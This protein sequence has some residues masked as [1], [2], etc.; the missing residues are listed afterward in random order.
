MSELENIRSLEKYDAWKKA[1]QSRE[2]WI[3]FI[4]GIIGGVIALLLTWAIL[5]VGI[6][7]VWSLGKGV[8]ASE[9]KIMEVVPK[10]EKVDNNLKKSIVSKPTKWISKK[11]DEQ[12][13]KEVSKGNLGAITDGVR[14]YSVILIFIWFVVLGII[15]AIFA[16]LSDWIIS[17]YFWKEPLLS[18]QRADF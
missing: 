10:I 12:V 13:A 5:R 17:K 8:F 15:W 7:D 2:S 11:Y 3:D 14:I 18:S 6:S 9:D 16:W 1:K 4:A